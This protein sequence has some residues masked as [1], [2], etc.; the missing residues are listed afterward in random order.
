[1]TC[2]EE[3]SLVITGIGV[4]VGIGVLVVYIL[5]LK[6]MKASVDASEKS[7]E[8]AQ[9]SADVLIASQ[10][11][12]LTLSFDKIVPAENVKIFG[13]I[14]NIGITPAYSCI[15]E[16]WMEVLPH[17]FKDF[18][19]AATHYKLPTPMTIYPNAPQATIVEV[20][21]DRAVEKTE[22]S[23]MSS[24]GQELCFRVRIQYRDAFEKCRWQDFGF[25]VGPK[26]IFYLPKYN[27]AG[28]CPEQSK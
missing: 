2:Y 5:Q 11:A 23:E 8:A 28:E 15:C 24:G 17:P 4:A 19:S 16:T 14:K 26:G 6:A 7:A 9:N 3:W 27:D 13:K 21:L 10:R 18:T 20:W 25:F 12:Q 22:I 1:M